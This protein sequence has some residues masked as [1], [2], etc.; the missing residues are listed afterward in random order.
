VLAGPAI[1]SRRR[2]CAVR[3]YQSFSRAL[4]PCFQGDGGGFWRDVMFAAGLK[5]PGVQRA[6]VRS[7][8]SPARRP[9]QDAV[10]VLGVGER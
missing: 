4:T 9:P 7:I 6:M 5:V 3:A 1:Y 8:A 2:W 10:A